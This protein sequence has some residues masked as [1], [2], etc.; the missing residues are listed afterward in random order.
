M[1][2]GQENPMISII[3]DTATTATIII[4]MIIIIIIIIIINNRFCRVFTSLI[5]VWREMS[6]LK[7]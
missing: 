1:V 5:S 6:A 4:M 2:G 3:I 7:N